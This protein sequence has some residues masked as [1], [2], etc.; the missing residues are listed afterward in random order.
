MPRFLTLPDV[1]EILNVNV[2]QVR[3]L[4]RS[5][6]LKGVQIGGRGMWRVED[7]QLEAY[8]KRAYEET[9]KRI[10]AGAEVEG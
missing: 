7:V 4:V 8:I 9:E 3:A 2:P 1:A 5:G 10:N 6:E